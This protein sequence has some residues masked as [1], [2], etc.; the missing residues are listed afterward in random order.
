MLIS[1]CRQIL[2]LANTASSTFSTLLSEKGTSIPA[3]QTFIVYVLLN[4]VYT[5]ITLYHY[6]VK[7]WARMVW[8]DGWRCKSTR[9]LS[10]HRYPSHKLTEKQTS[11]KPSS[12][13]KATT[14]PS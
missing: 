8:T 5:S 4:I 12:T 1:I 14:S 13:S 6:G 3:F 7:K 11:S 2:A 10:P 9:N